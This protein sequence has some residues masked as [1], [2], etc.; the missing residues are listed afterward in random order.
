MKM[1]GYR[2]HLSLQTADDI[3]YQL[4]MK[5]KQYNVDETRFHA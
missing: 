1:S 2:S 5:K 3:G 4:I